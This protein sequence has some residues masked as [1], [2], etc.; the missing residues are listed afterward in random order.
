M[1]TKTPDKSAARSLAA[2]TG[3]P[4]Q[5]CLS[6]VAVLRDVPADIDIGELADLVAGR[7]IETSGVE[8]PVSLFEETRLNWG[9]GDAIWMT[10]DDPAYIRGHGTDNDAAEYA[11]R[12]SGSGIDLSPDNELWLTNTAEHCRVREGTWRLGVRDLL[13]GMRRA[14]SIPP[15]TKLHASRDDLAIKSRGVRIAEPLFDFAEPSFSPYRDDQVSYISHRLID[16]V[17]SRRSPGPGFDWLYLAFRDLDM[18]LPREEDHRLVECDGEG[19]AGGCG[20]LHDWPTADISR[21][22][23]VLPEPLLLAWREIVGDRVVELD[24]ESYS[25][26]RMETRAEGTAGMLY[27]LDVPPYGILWLRVG[28][29]SEDLAPMAI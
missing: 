24:N 18:A 12:L 21:E 3:R 23:L 29:H 27:G 16:V 13:D 5:S 9:A 20:W 6:A 25:Y 2:L 14:K 11:L 10:E 22:H 19:P 28:P 7:P 1:T 8:L 17:P 15:P 4:Y 26:R